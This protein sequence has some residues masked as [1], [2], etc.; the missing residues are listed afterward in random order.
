VWVLC[1]SCRSWNLTPL[2]ERWEAVEAAERLFEDAALGART[3]NI[4]LG[5]VREG[6]ELIR[7]GRADRP[8]FAGWRFGRQLVSRRR[9]FWKGMGLAG[10]SG[11]VGFGISVPLIASGLTIG[12]FVPSAWVLGGGAVDALRTHGTMRSPA[13]K[14][15]NGETLSY[16]DITRSRLVRTESDEGWGIVVARKHGSDLLVTGRA[17]RRMLRIGMPWINVWGSSGREVRD[18]VAHVEEFGSPEA[19]FRCAA[20]TL[21]DASSWQIARGKSGVIAAA[22]RRTILALEMAANEETERAALAGEMHLLEEE[23]RHAEELAAIADRL[24][25]PRRL[26]KRLKQL[27][28]GR[29]ATK[30][31]QT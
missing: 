10:V 20:E 16:Y 31:E 5:R 19:I 9:R 14:A 3:E 8:E 15:P 18:A 28:A 1:P 4:S 7:I 26:E 22:P 24:L 29:P 30:G 25:F 17:A 23:W 21:K 2:E 12:P 11:L 13:A 27:K 6:L